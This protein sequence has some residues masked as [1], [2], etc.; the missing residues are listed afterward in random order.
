MRDAGLH[1]TLIQVRAVRSKDLLMT[2][3]ATEECEGGIEEE[4]PHY[5]RAAKKQA[6]VMLHR[7]HRETGE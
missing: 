2:N 4:R 6:R 1:Q 3:H 7:D 5:E